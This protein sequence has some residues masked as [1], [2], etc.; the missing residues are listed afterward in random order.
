MRARKWSLSHGILI[1]GG[2]SYYFHS[3]QTILTVPCVGDMA[4]S[5]GDSEI[6]RTRL[7][8]SLPMQVTIQPDSAG[9]HQFVPL[10]SATKFGGRRSA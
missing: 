4:F 7:N 6:A 2:E 5:F 1:A 8:L 10:F 9:P 3:L